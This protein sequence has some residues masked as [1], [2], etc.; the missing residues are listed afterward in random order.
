MGLATRFGENVGLFNLAKCEFNKKKSIVFI[1]LKFFFFFFQM[2][3]T[4]KCVS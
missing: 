2:Q 3:K 4:W 1:L